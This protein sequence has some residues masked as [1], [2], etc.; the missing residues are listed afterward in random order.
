MQVILKQ[1][2]IESAI[3][4]YISNQGINLQGKSIEVAFTAGRK[5]S[6]ISAEIA[7]EDADDFPVFH[8][9][10]TKVPSRGVSLVVNTDKDEPEQV[11]GTSPV[12]APEAE[13]AAEETAVATDAAVIKTTSLFN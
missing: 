4:Q 1:T 3:K 8:N 13:D 11:Q 7:I 5:E 12:P 2:E 6:G 10:E 9:P